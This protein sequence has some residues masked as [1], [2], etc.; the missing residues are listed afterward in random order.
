MWVWLLV[1]CLGTSKG[2]AVDDTSGDSDVDTVESD[3]PAETDP[4]DSDAA[5]ETDPPAVEPG[6]E[7]GTGA[8]ALEPLVDG[9]DLPQV[10]GPQG[11]WHVYGSVRCH[12]IVAG[13]TENP[14]NPEN[15]VVTWK[16]DDGGRL[17][18]GYEGLPRPM[19]TPEGAALTGELIVFRTRT[20]EETL[21]LDV[22]M[23]FH[24]VDHEGVTIDLRRAVHLIAE[25]TDPPVDPPVDSPPDSPPG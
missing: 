24:L 14:L 1:G 25:A 10:R 8:T 19:S 4:A 22:Q 17:V 2:D 11:G 6:C 7:L 12:G 15:P 21:G 23:V 3:P 13:D 20:Y 18:A 9:Q 16:L 5:V